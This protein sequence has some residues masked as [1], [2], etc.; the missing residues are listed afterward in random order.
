MEQWS[1]LVNIVNYVQYDRNPKNVYDLDVKAIDQK[2]HKKIYDRLKEEHRHVL[3]LDFGKN[4]DI[5]CEECLDMYEGAQSE[6]LSTTRF[7]EN[8]D[9]ST[10]CLDRIDMTR[11]SK[12]PYFRTR[13]YSRKIIRR[14]GRSDTFRHRNKQIIYVQVTLFKM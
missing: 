5:L 3:E 7:D 12:I 6:L 13:I 2:N 8:S 14:Y 11:A 1:T 10:T 9:L 4:P